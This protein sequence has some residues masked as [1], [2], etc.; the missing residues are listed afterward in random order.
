MNRILYPIYNLGPGKRI[1]IWVQGC[2]L[3]CQGC[4]S[5]S[6]WPE[7][8]GRKIEIEYLVHQIRK[9]QGHFDGITISGGEPFDQYDA[10]IAFSTFIKKK[11][12]LNVFVFSGYRLDELKN[13]FRDHLFMTSID[14]LMDDR[15][16]QELHDDTNT[17]GSGNQ[18]LYH[19]QNNRPRLLEEC[20]ESSKWSVCITP[21]HKMF[22]SGIPKKNE[23]NLIKTRLK[24]SGI[25]MEYK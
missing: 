4:I 23:L 2:S 16:R 6:L 7:N 8:G 18:K 12:K 9:I 13:K 11:T 22:L 3:K 10:L 25:N 19:F 5:P 21:D 15:Y 1:G 14:Y 17:R 24:N 20:F